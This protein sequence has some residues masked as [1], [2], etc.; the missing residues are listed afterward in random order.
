MQVTWL[1][2]LV[3]KPYNPKYNSWNSHGGRVVHKLSSDLHMHIVVHMST[4]TY[5]KAN[6]W[7][8]LGFFFGRTSYTK[9]V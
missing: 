1:G 9:P 3:A 5:M 2:W 4:H 6:S 8:F 7:I